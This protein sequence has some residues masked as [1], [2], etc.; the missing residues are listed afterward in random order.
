MPISRVRLR[1]HERH[2]AV[3][4][5]HREQ[6]RDAPKPL[7]QRRHHP[8]RRQR[9]IDLVLERPE[10]MERKRRIDAGDAARIEANAF[11]GLPRTLSVE[12]GRRRPGAIDK[13]RRTP[14]RSPPR[15][16]R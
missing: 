2:D 10:R 11:S 15:M 1:D 8:L 12:R 14:V 16:P 13:R 4:P 9:A 7:R 5:D 6:Q 3:E